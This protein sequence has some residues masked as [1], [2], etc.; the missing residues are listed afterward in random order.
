MKILER[1]QRRIINRDPPGKRAL[2][3]ELPRFYYSFDN[4]TGYNEDGI[5]IFEEDWDNLILLDA[6]RHDFFKREA[7]LPGKY[8]TRISRGSMT[9]EWMRANFSGRQL[10]DTVYITANANYANIKDELDTEF[11]DY[12]GLLQDEYRNEHG[13]INPKTVTER[14]LKAAEKYP[15]K[16]LM[17]HYVQPHVPY[18]RPT[19]REHFDPSV[20]LKDFPETHEFTH[21]I[22][23]EAYRE[24]DQI[25]LNE[26]AKLLTSFKGKTIVSA[27]HGEL[28][29]ERILSV[30]V[31]FYGHP[32]GIYVDELVRVP[33]QIYQNGERKELYEDRP[34]KS[35]QFELSEVE[36]QLERLG[37]KT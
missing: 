22:L 12:I 8:E 9:R 5:D 29:G 30:P 16:R 10:H 7:D 6:C 23:Q 28:L 21:D 4:P 25:A 3:R 2:L 31:R 17:I 33:W 15:N 11:H 24:N 37:Y 34:V 13:A 19:G 1:V 35:Q 20:P 18:I 27:D 36:K 32:D 26:A 14:A